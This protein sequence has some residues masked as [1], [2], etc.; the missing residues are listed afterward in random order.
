MSAVDSVYVT[1]MTMHIVMIAAAANL[2]WPKWKK[3]GRPTHSAS[4]TL[5][6]STRPM[7]HATTVPTTTLIKAAICPTKPRKN[8]LTTRI[9]RIT[10]PASAMRPTLPTYLSP[11]ASS[12]RINVM[13]APA[14]DRPMMQI[15][16]PATS[17]GKNR[18]T[19]ENGLAIIRPK[20][21]EMRIAPYTYGRPLAPPYW[22]AMM[23][24]GFSTVKVA[25]ATTATARRTAGSSQPTG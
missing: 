9:V 6:K 20:M 8:R 10:N 21:P 1:I 17:G 12:P 23:I 7:N 16:V 22:L 11:C 19:M 13:P 24:I 5:L 18:S 25:P 4:E 2:G 14:S 3:C 15:T